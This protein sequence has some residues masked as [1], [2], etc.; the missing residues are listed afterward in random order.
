MKKRSVKKKRTVLLIEDDP[1]IHR[2]VRHYLTG[3]IDEL[4]IASG[5]RQ[6]LAMARENRP[7]LILLDIGLPD[8]SG[9]NVLKSLRS[10][11]ATR[12]IPVL[13][14]TAKSDT[15]SIVRGLEAGAVD[16]I[17]KPFDGPVFQSRVRSAMTRAPESARKK[18]ESVLVIDDDPHILKLV[19]HFLKGYARVY[20]AE[21]A[22]AGL[23]MA[24]RFQPSVILLDLNLPARHGFDVCRDL[25][26]NPKTAHISVVFLTADKGVS[27]QA[28][29]I[30]RGAVDYIQKPISREVLVARVRAAARRGNRTV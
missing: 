30:D 5:G 2:L 21:T 29:G 17:T 26:A 24:L 27:R 15:R 28:A 14:L 23:E 12:G 9:M 8:L 20:P 7:S 19:S 4:W 25:L 1:S 10:S 22:Q 16:Y 3:T 6:G 13:F 18:L 11:G